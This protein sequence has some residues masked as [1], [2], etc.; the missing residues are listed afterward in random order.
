MTNRKFI[1][2]RQFL[3]FLGVTLEAG[4]EAVV[5]V[6][7]DG[8]QIADLPHAMQPV[9]ESI[10]GMSAKDTIPESARGVVE[11]IA[12]GRSGKTYISS[13]YVLYA[14]LTTD[15]EH[16]A[17]G[18]HAF[19]AIIAPNKELAKQ[20]FNYVRGAILND[21]TL[22]RLVTSDRITSITL[23]QRPGG[24]PVVIRPFAA[25]RGGISG[26]GKSLVSF[27]MSESCFFRDAATGVVNDEAVFKAASARVIRGGKSVLESTPWVAS[28]LAYTLYKENYGIP[29]NCL[30]AQASTRDMRT[31]EHILSIVDREYERDPENAK[32]EYGA[33]WGSSS[34]VT[35]FTAEDVSKLFSLDV[36]PPP[37]P[38]GGSRLSAAT[39][40]A[41]VRNSAVLAMS[42]RDGSRNNIFHLEEVRPGGEPLVPSEVCVGFGGRMASAG[43]RSVVADTHYRETLRESVSALGVALVASCGPVERMVSFRDALRAGRVRMWKHHPLRRRVTAQMSKI[44]GGLLPGG[45]YNVKLPKEADGSHCDLVDCIARLVWA[46]EN[47]IVTVTPK[48]VSEEERMEQ[49]MIRS[50]FNEED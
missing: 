6:L 50:K 23:L 22:S 45:G 33:Q 27:L 17:P 19:G 12:G 40:L 10:F 39:D 49:A 7:F 2:F 32:I 43:V 24:K 37:T 15:I 11:L 28:G 9:A 13:L 34:S 3:G 21:P 31:Q 1:T 44:T 5:R 20:N 46:A 18:E 16:L 4:Q 41:F 29:T 14:S 25:D 38:P 35:F 47:N 42:V 26:R 36:E 8:E 30:V 48:V